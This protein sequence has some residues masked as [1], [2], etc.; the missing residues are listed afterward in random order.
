MVPNYKRPKYRD[1]IYDV[2]ERP[3]D[4]QDLDMITHIEELENKAKFNDKRNDYINEISDLVKELYDTIY[5]PKSPMFG[6]SR[7]QYKKTFKN[8]LNTI[9]VLSEAP[10]SGDD[11]IKARVKGLDLDKWSDYE[12]YY[13][14]GEESLYE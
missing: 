1:Y 12:A 9:I 13:R 14:L 10:Y 4:D 3:L 5:N 11:F 2:L 8:L 7:E 6:K